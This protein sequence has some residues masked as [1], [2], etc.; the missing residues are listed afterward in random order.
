MIKPF[1][2]AAAVLLSSCVDYGPTVLGEI[3]VAVALS[4][5]PAE[6]VSV[7][8]RL[9]VGSY[10]V[11]YGNAERR[12]TDP[13]QWAD[14]AT[15]RV[16]ASLKVDILALQET[17]DAWQ[18]ALEDALTELPHCRFHAPKKFLPGGLGACSRYPI[19]EDELVESPVGWFPAQR[20]VLDTPRGKVEVLNVHLKP[21]IASPDGWWDAQRATR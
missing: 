8:L 7:P 14:A 4:A 18:G 2:F 19:L 5:E 21:P 13:T 1:P 15:V 6:P 11:Y 12:G 20:V 16:A 10:N 9:R 3:P 17:N